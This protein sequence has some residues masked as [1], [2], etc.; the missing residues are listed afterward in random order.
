MF[1]CFGCI[2]S[3]TRDGILY[4]KP[5]LTADYK[6]DEFIRTERYDM[7]GSQPGDR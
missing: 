2:S 5:T 6:S 4:I 1:E 3:Y 7:W